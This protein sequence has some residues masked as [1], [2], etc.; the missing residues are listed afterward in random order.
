M[1]S[2]WGGMFAGIE[3]VGVESGG[4]SRGSAL[5][6]STSVLYLPGL[7]VVW[8]ISLNPAGSGFPAG[9]TNVVMRILLLGGMVWVV[10]GGKLGSGNPGAQVATYFDPWVSTKIAG[11]GS[12]GS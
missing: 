5:M 12:V 8:R 1:S 3:I 2:A 7:E 4:M 6:L 10:A 11:S 9:W